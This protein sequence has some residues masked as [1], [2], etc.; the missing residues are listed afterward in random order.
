MYQDEPA[1]MDEQNVATDSR[2]LSRAYC[3]KLHVH[4]DGTFSIVGPIQYDK[5]E[6]GLRED[7]Q[8][9]T[10]ESLPDALKLI[11]V[12][13]REN[14]IGDNA[15]ADMDAGYLAGPGGKMGLKDY[16]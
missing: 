5:K 9:Q 7:S 1:E 11:M 15:Q 8:A 4:E 10:A 2:N 13:V 14:P 6:E 12:T 3:I 16:R